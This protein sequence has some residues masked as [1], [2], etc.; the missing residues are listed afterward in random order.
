MILGGLFEPKEVKYN[1][2][3]TPLEGEKK[4]TNA[5]SSEM[6]CTPHTTVESKH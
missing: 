5:V 4:R 3:K 6:E 1:P 2:G